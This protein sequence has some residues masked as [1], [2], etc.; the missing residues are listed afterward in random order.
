MNTNVSNLCPCLL[1]VFE[2]F[3]LAHPFLTQAPSDGQYHTHA[4]THTRT[5]RHTRT[6]TRNR[7]TQAHTQ[8]RA[9]T[10]RQTDRQTDAH[11]HTHT[12][13][14]TLPERVLVAERDA[15]E[16]DDVDV[17]DLDVDVALVLEECG[18]AV[19]DLPHEERY[20]QGHNHTPQDP[21]EQ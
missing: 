2:D 15:R 6:L 12:H 5:H 16:V 13:D 21:E 10:D 4:R 19:A 3:P 17:V 8:T 9:D 18:D 1:S 11:T 20:G 14:S 7:H